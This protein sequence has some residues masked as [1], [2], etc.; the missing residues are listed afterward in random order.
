MAVLLTFSPVLAPSADRQLDLFV[1][2]HDG[3]L[4]HIRQTAPSE[5]WTGWDSYGHP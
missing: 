4:Y 2:G 1:V 3:S 5:R